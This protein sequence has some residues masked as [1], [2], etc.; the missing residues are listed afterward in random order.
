MEV[1]FRHTTQE[2]WQS[3]AEEKDA[4]PV[5]EALFGAP[6]SQE[7]TEAGGPTAETRSDNDW[8]RG[9]TSRLL[10]LVNSEQKTDEGLP[11]DAVMD[12]RVDAD[13]KDAEIGENIQES[14]H[15]P[16]KQ[17]VSISVPNARLFYP[18]PTFHG[19]RTGSGD[20]VLKPWSIR[21]GELFVVS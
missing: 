8:V 3:G 7:D 14:A 2:G 9:K 17:A 19:H 15:P 10:D 18:Q 21:R 1:S 20:L 11:T 4:S 16:E 12:N 6:L 13:T 5:Q